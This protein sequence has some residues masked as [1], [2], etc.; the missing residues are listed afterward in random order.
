MKTIEYDDTKHIDEGS[1]ITEDNP[2][3]NN[4]N[5]KRQLNKNFSINKDTCPKEDVI[6]HSK[7]GRKIKVFGRVI[8][9]K[10]LFRLPSIV[11]VEV[12]SGVKTTELNKYMFP[13]TLF[14]KKEAKMA[15]KYLCKSCPIKS[16]SY[17]IH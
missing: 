14:M 3:L 7:K 10:G 5:L 13:R 8:K 11:N 17:K 9:V 2:N 15:R 4:W 12:K 6:L 1:E 16:C